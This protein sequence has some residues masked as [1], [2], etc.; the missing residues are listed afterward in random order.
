MSEIV[1]K[2]VEDKAPITG[3]QPVMDEKGKQVGTVVQRAVLDGVPMRDL[4]EA[5]YLKLPD[6]LRRAVLK[7]PYFV[8]SPAAANLPLPPD[9]DQ[10]EVA[11][12]VAEEPKK[13]K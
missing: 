13:K 4:T 12:A 8:P 1:F 10:A 11:P 5:D 3:Y 7:A 6:R 9:E 2:Y